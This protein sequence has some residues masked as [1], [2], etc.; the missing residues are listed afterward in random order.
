MAVTMS[1]I[2]AIT[3]EIYEGP[4][5]EQINNDT[6]A[7]SRIERSGNGIE[8]TV[9]GKYVTFPIH[10]GRNAGVGSRLEM[11][12]LPRAGHQA[13]APARVR[14]GHHYG[15]IQLSGQALRLAD[16]NTQAFIAALDL[17]TQGI[18]DDLAFSQNRQVYGNGKG[19]LAVIGAGAAG[20]HAVKSGIDYL[21]I[22][23]I[24]DVYDPA[25]MDSATGAAKKLN[26]IV[27][28]YEDG[29]DGTG[30]V[31]LHD[32]STGTPYNAADDDVLAIAGSARKEWIGL[33]AITSPTGV[34]YDVDPDEVDQWRGVT[35]A[36]GGI[37][38]PLSEGLILSNVDKVRRRGGKTS[39]LLT[40]LGVR[41]AY[42]LLLEQQ[43]RYVGTNKF[44]GGFGGLA[45]TTDQGD[46]PMMTDPHA[47]FNTMWG[48]SEKNLK[49][50]R[51]KD[52]SFMD[53]DGSIWVRVPG[54]TPGTWKDAYSATMFQYSQL[55]TD[56]RGVHFKIA[57]ITEG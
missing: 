43:R 50:Y 51:E 5:R 52:W 4:M 31:T 48:L 55:G 15:T 27:V 1:T 2:S 37:N 41:R 57:D 28:K 30:Q 14:L 56:R 35:D 29:D 45:F 8:S 16:T 7:L 21:H 17:E 3:K 47:P 6:P 19:K 25:V 10:Y 34:L 23:Q 36:N 18:K 20:V 54:D 44:E 11:E 32:L 26:V 9:G 38:R 22:N 40:S 33:E 24:L 49:L 12:D 13:T 39:L 46:I 42:F 53:E